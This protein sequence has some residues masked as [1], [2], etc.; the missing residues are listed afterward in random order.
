[1]RHSITLPG[2]LTMS[3]AISLTCNRLETTLR[4]TSRR[5]WKTSAAPLNLNSDMC[6][7][8]G[9][10]MLRA[11]FLFSLL[12]S[13]ASA[14]PPGDA[15]ATGIVGADCVPGWEFVLRLADMPSGAKAYLIYYGTNYRSDTW[16]PPLH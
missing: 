12:V 14:G 13:L 10:P 1:M 5:R 4:S 2:K 8:K 7:M 3:C 6:K 15:P 9:I 11:L 16:K